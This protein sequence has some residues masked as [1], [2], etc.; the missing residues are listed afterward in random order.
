MNGRTATDQDSVE[1][2]RISEERHRLLAEAANDVIW[3]MSVDGRITYVSPSVERMRGFTQEEAMAQSLDEIETPESAAISRRYFE[4][5]HAALREGRVPPADFRG[6]L[7]YLCKDGSTVITDVHVIPHLDGEGRLVEILGVTRDISERKEAEAEVLRSR[8]EARE[9]WAALTQA[10]AELRRLATVDALTGVSNRRHFDELVTEAAARAARTGRQSSLVLFDIDHFKRINDAHG[11]RRGDRVLVELST[12]VSNR[13][14]STDA[15]GRWG[16]EE[17]VLLL[18]EAG[19][20]DALDVAE[21]V[22]RIVADTPFPIAGSVTVSVGVA[23][24]RDGEDIDAW[25]TR[26]DA[27]MYR[28]KAAGRNVVRREDG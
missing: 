16:G 1:A 6:E 22:R 20:D 23:E 27:A 4:E 17:F 24:S 18:R 25:M 11:H 14:R 21:E 13:L 3:T 10:N 9:A 7:E 15:L 26:A 28:A 2:L 12:R 5:L 19:I 8:N